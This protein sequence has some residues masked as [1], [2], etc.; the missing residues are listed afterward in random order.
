MGM[1]SRS[2]AADERWKR[3]AAVVAANGSRN[4]RACEGVYRGARRM[5]GPVKSV[6]SG[7]CACPRKA[8]NGPALTS[9]SVLEFSIHGKAI[10]R[11]IAGV[12]LPERRSSR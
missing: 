6:Q 8:A 9:M 1:S 5:P 12:R 2:R 4:F 10:L 11:G 3:P 7:S